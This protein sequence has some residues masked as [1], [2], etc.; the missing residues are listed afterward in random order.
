VTSYGSE[1]LAD[2]IIT[3]RGAVTA[4]TWHDRG[5]SVSSA[6]RKQHTT[7]EDRHGANIMLVSVTERTREIGVLKSIGATRRGILAQFL[8]AAMAIVTLG[9]MLGVAAGWGLSVL[10]G[11]L[12]LLGAIFK[13]TSGQGDIH[14]KSRWR[15]C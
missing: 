14:C 6:T 9:G 10:F 4:S 5:L 13:D 2:Y 8:L 12:P 1:R 11:T 7:V 15:R 3:V